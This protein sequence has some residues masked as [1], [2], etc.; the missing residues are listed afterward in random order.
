MC[1]FADARWWQWHT[2]GIAKRWPWISFTKEQVREAFRTFAGEKV[3]IQN[4][5]MMVTDP[6]VFMLHNYGGDGISELSNGI[7]TGSNSGYQAINVAVLAGAKR[8]L[9]LGYDMRFASGR[10]HSHGGHPVQMPEDAY[11][12]YA[13]KFSSMVPHLKRLGVEVLN[14]TPSSAIT[15]FPAVGLASVLPNP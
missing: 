13:R 4:T 9:L 15:C 1:Y 6:E 2:D 14:C 7:K 5:G 11:R 8:V 10:T 12:S 3:T